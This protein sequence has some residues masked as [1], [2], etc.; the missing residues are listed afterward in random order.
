MKHA[1]IAVVPV[2][3]VALGL[4]YWL[5]ASSS[6]ATDSVL[7][8]SGVLEA[9]S[10]TVVAE[11]AGK[12]ERVFV[13]EGDEVTAGAVLATLDSAALEAK[14]RQAR[15]ARRIAELNLKLASS[16]ARSEQV[17]QARAAM[18]QAA[19]QRAGALRAYGLAREAYA[20]RAAESPAYVQAR[21][22]VAVL[23]NQRQLLAGAYD[24]ARS[25]DASV[26]AYEAKFALDEAAAAYERA[27]ALAAE[28]SQALAACEAYLGSLVPDYLVVSGGAYV[29]STHDPAYLGIAQEALAQYAEAKARNAEAKAA[30]SQAAGVLAAAQSAYA[31]ARTVGEMTKQKDVAALQRQ[32]ESVEAQLDAA[33]DAYEQARALYEAGINERSLMSQARTQA[34]VAAAAYDA[35]KAQY[36][37][38]LAGATPEQRAIADAQLDQ[39]E[40]ALD[41]ALAY[42][43]RATL[44]APM[45]GIVQDAFFRRGE[46]VLPGSPL[47]RIIDPERISLVVYIEEAYLGRIRVGQPVS[48]VVDAFADRSFRGTIARISTEAEFTPT[49]VQTKSE[50]TTTVYAVTIRVRNEGGVLKAGMPADARIDLGAKR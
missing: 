7:E 9:E 39:A 11:V 40:A 21:S 44:R 1:R 23:E 4:A 37:L 49:G 2:A 47:F 5:Y 46:S 33:N 32:L 42:L 15:A 18:D 50:R 25:V 34:D 31:A 6:G 43:D 10:V 36:D 41:E 16:P 8:A 14:V 35:A 26:Y 17:R 30:L 20:M 3:L 12:V 22:Q 19:A 24:A 45:R 29:P 48:V 13:E 27:A 38:L 28:T